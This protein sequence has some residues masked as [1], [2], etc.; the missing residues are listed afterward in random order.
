MKIGFIGAGNLARALGELLVAGGH[1]VAFTGRGGEDRPARDVGP[2]AD[3]AEADLV[4]LAVPFSAAREVLPGLSGLLAGK[5]VVDATNPVN[6]DWSPML[7]GQESSAGE[8][9][10]RALPGA[11]VVKA[12]NTVFADAMREDRL[13]RAGARVTCFVASDHADARACVAELARSAGFAPLEVGPLAMSRHLEAM[14][15]LNI[16]IAVGMQGGTQGAFIYHRAD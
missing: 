11:Q 13:V 10:A 9:V 14:A 6:P 3:A 12:F 8:E 7:L 4:V 15:H 1:S 16:Q 5:L 2:L